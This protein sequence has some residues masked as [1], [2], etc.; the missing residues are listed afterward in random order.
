[1][2]EYKTLHTST[3]IDMAK[4]LDIEYR[5]SIATVTLHATDTKV[6][7]LNADFLND[8]EA[9]AVELAT[10]DDISGAIVASSLKGGFIAGA[11]IGEIEQ[12]TDPDKGAELAAVGQRIFDRWAAL[13]FPV[14]AA[15]HGHCMGGGT[16]FALACDY[17]I[18]GDSAIIALPEIK[19][20]ILPGFG[21][22]QRLPRLVTIEKSLDIILSGRNVRSSEALKCGLADR[23]VDDNNLEAA[24]EEFLREIIADNRPVLA[25][26]KSIKSGWRHFLLEKNPFGRQLLFSKARQQLLKK[27]GGHYPAPLKALETI[28]TTLNL[29]IDTG[30]QIEAK[31]L[32]ELI[33]TPE[34]K[35]LVHLFHLS[36]RPRKLA[37]QF[38]SSR[39]V[40][41][42]AVLG[43]G[44]MGGG[45]A[46]LLVSRG[47]PTILK[48][49]DQKALDAG[50]EHARDLFRKKVKQPSGNE[51]KRRETMALLT[52]SLDYSQFNE[53]DLVIEAVVENISVKQEVLQEAEKHLPENAIFASNTS[54][55]SISE[56]QSAAQRDGQ[57][58]GLHFFNPV[59]KMPLIE[60][61]KGE[62]S[63]DETTAT[64]YQL[65]IR[66]GKTPIIT[67][68]RTG[69][70]VNRL[71][72]TYLLEAALLATEGV[73]WQSIDKLIAKFGYPMGPFRLVDE[74]GMDIAAEVGDTLC[75]AFP[76]LKP[77]D[78]LHRVLKLNLLGKKGG[79]GFYN[80]INGRSEGVNL[81]IEPVV[82]ATDRLAGRTELKR[83]LYLMV[84]EAARCLEEGIV[85]APE[86]I[87]TGLVFGT[88]FPPF[89]GGLCRWADAEGLAEITRTLDAFASQ[90]GERFVPCNYL[91]EHKS[92]Y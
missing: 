73:N 41:K 29:S 23:L 84:N 20:G 56:L 10:R 77:T 52:A 59:E 36:Q 46:H 48:D 65:A 74:V 25:R 32:G 18:L 1:L 7:I 44:V 61:V 86:D 35:N 64:L 60:V 5:D 88:G 49:I 8:L 76:Y 82:P 28:A 15:I 54:A 13:P 68:D 83:L 21:G 66:L 55:L 39:E 38:Q 67:A 40:R 92:F 79:K 51:D 63:N 75:S 19:L 2:N 72:V 22:T 26:R 42:A 30:L 89:L 12:V 37:D 47:I 57:V 85:N 78:L 27:T 43:A 53:V 6:N 4:N 58:G 69:F 70:L 3:G 71:L 34:S 50:V 24:A 90:Q 31:A 9:A 14:L 45:I 62:K 11:D 87:D 81:E 33:V 80:Y 17:R 16:E 91:K